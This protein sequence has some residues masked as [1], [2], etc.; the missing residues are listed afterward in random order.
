[1]YVLRYL[2]RD[3]YTQKAKFLRSLRRGMRVVCFGKQHEVKLFHRKL[4][5]MKWNCIW[6]RQPQQKCGSPCRKNKVMRLYIFSE[7]MCLLQNI[8]YFILNFYSYKIFMSQGIEMTHFT[9]FV[10][11]IVQKYCVHIKTKKQF[12]RSM[13]REQK[14]GKGKKVT[15]FFAHH[16]ESSSSFMLD[17]IFHFHFECSGN[18]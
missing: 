3:P 13:H 8:E 16:F 1:M 18:K 10:Q 11:N 15:P 9:Y 17:T 2:Q 6:N 4:S 14:Y 12:I 5:D 7:C